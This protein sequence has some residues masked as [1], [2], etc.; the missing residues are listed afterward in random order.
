MLAYITE[1]DILRWK[2]EGRYD[3]LSRVRERNVLWSGD[4][5]VSASGKRLKNCIYLC[6]DGS[7]FLCEIYNTRPLVCRN[8]I[9]GSS[10]LCPLCSDKK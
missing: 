8:Y 4:R 3:I 2:K 5:M 1:P 6:R 9:P 7:S 10:E